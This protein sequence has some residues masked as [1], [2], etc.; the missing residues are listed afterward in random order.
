[1]RP[2]PTFTAACMNGYSVGSPEEFMQHAYINA[3]DCCAAHRRRI[4][5]HSE[6]V[7]GPS[8]LS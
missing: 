1:M 5:K 2:Q 3:R 6:A 7:M 8:T 4:L